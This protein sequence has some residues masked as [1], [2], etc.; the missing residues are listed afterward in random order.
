MNTTA[1]FV[2]SGPQ[3]HHITAKNVPVSA[4]WISK[5]KRDRQTRRTTGPDRGDLSI[6]EPSF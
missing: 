1:H 2:V 5:G 4:L 3:L 6:L